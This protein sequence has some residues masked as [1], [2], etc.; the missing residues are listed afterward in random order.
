MAF[1][2]H[3]CSFVALYLPTGVYSRRS[4]QE[5]FLGARD[6]GSRA[7]YGDYGVL[8]EPVVVV[9][10]A[11]KLRRLSVVE[12]LTERRIR[13]PTGCFRECD[14]NARLLSRKGLSV[15]LSWRNR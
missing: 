7:S 13:C 11:F 10:T 14:G 4:R 8:V 12:Y 15:R 1:W 2:R 5:Q 9:A 6:R 3:V